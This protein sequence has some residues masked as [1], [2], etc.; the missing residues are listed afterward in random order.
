MRTRLIINGREV[1]NPASRTLAAIVGLAIL[2]LLLILLLPLIGFV[3]AVGAGLLGT[4]IV[5]RAIGRR[6]ARARLRREEEEIE[7]AT[8]IESK[9]HTTPGLPD[10]DGS[11]R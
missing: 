3:V 9:R 1:D 2:A 7:E 11:G 10:K 4:A 8:V 5:I 6:R